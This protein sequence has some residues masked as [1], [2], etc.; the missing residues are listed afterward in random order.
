MHPQQ[1]QCLDERPAGRSAYVVRK[2]GRHLNKGDASSFI[3][4]ERS[5]HIGS[6]SLMELQ[7]SKGLGVGRS[8]GSD[9][10]GRFTSCCVPTHHNHITPELPYLFRKHIPRIHHMGALHTLYLQSRGPC[11]RSNNQDIR[12]VFLYQRRFQ[13]YVQLHIHPGKRHAGLH[14][15]NDFCELLFSGRRRS[16]KN[17]ATQTVFLFIQGNP[18][19]SL[20]S[21]KGELHAG[22][23]ASRN[24]D[25]LWRLCLFHLV[26]IFISRP[27]IQDTGHR[28]P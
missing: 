13:F 11:S 23:A 27:G 15:V 10:E 26:N 7:K 12:L 24:H 18:V 19:A 21:R 2:T 6:L 3:V 22:R 14:T 4:K 17:L 5:K 25:F 9:K 16:Q 20:G 28:R 1:F 8:H